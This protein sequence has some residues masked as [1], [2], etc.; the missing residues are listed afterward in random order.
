MLCLAAV[1]AWSQQAK[2]PEQHPKLET[3]RLAFTV[4]ELEGDRTVNSRSYEV[5]M[6]EALSIAWSQIRVGNRVPIN[7]GDKGAQYSDVGLSLDVGLQRREETGPTLTT[8]FD[9]TSL[10]PEQSAGQNLLPLQ[11]RVSM[12][13]QAELTPGKPLLLNS[14]DDVNSKRRYQLVVTATRLK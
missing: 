9:L 7:A 3:Y 2:A 1:P 11:R 5:V 10:V 12:T 8:R 6:Q 14:A 4:N 13:S